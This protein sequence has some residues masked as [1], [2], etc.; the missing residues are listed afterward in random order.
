MQALNSFWCV[1][2]VE[3]DGKFNKYGAFII[4]GK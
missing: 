2:N 3:L 1:E 4:V